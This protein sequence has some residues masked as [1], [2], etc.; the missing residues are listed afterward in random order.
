MHWHGH[1]ALTW[2][3]RDANQKVLCPPSV[4][5]RSLNQYES[6]PGCSWSTLDLGLR[7]S[8]KA[9][10]CTAKVE[11]DDFPPEKS[12]ELLMVGW[13]KVLVNKT[14][15]GSQEV[16]HQGANCRASASNVL[17]QRH[18]PW[19]VTTIDSLTLV[20]S[21]LSVSCRAKAHQGAICGG[22]MCI[23]VLFWL[24]SP[25]LFNCPYCRKFHF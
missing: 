1:I 12:G 9:P 15:L 8:W 6:V 7:P 24:F 3:H 13:R 16:S 20:L 19:S 22:H 4:P 25:L 5:S 23:Q 10:R 2:T 18:E 17:R 14:L 11:S 21:K